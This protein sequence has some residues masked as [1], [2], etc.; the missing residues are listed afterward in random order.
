MVSC[1]RLTAGE[2]WLGEAEQRERAGLPPSATA[3]AA[4]PVRVWNGTGGEGAAARNE[5]ARLALVAFRRAAAR[6]RGLAAL[7]DAQRARGVR[8]VAAALARGCGVWHPQWGSAL[9]LREWADRREAEALAGARRARAAYA[10]L[11][12][13]A[14]EAANNLG[15]CRFAGCPSGVSRSRQPTSGLPPR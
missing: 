8:A 3:A 14:A 11:A 1:G 15:V 12:P 6:A 2:A 9:L 10:A 4:R 7:V 13:V 5:A